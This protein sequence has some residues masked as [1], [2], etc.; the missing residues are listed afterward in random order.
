MLKHKE[1]KETFFDSYVW[2]NFIPKDHKY[3][4]IKGL[5]DVNFIP[6]LVKDSY[7]N[8]HPQ[9][10]DP[11]DPRIL[12]LMCIVE[13]L[14]NLSDVQVA[15][16]LAEVPVLKWFV[17]LA[18][19]D[20]VPDDTTLCKFRTQRMGE[21]NFKEAFYKIVNQIKEMGL[22]DGQVQSQDA[23]A[24]WAD[25]ALFNVFQLLNKCRQN[26]LQAI[27]KTAGQ[28]RYNE[29]TKRYDFKLIRNPADK[30]K[31]F[32]SLI[33]VCQGLFNEIKKSRGLLKN[34]KVKKEMQILGRALSERQDEYFDEDNKKQKK[35]EIDKIKG[36]MINPSDPDASW[37]AKSETKYFAG[38]KA[39]VNMDHLYDF[40]TAI[41]VMNAGHPEEQGAAP[42]LRE[43]QKY[44]GIIPKHFMADAKYSAG[45]TRL[46]LKALGID[47]LYLPEVRPKHRNNKLYT[48]YAF[49]WDWQL[50]NLV[51]P[52][53]YPAEY[54]H[55][56]DEKLGFEFQ[57]NERICSR[58]EL[59]GQCTGAEVCGRKVL[60]P[61]TWWDHK[62]GFR[63]MDTEEYKIMYKEQRYKIERKNADL[64]KWHG[65]G[66]V[67]YRGRARVRIQ[68][69]LTALAVN[70]K[71]WVKF[72]MGKLK[73]GINETLAK[74][75]A[76]APP[77]GEVRSDT[78]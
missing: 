28:T 13:Y 7:K 61:H 64:K 2:N 52:A 26:L 10:N 60:L 68:A 66:R 71:K 3:V 53:G 74:L 59:K 45:T 38:Y 34:K 27:L 29:L 67:R 41:N 57:F 69:F 62:E 21:E 76:L 51:C 9:G 65:F 31:H 24:I 43:Q 23:T 77:E 35:E 18:P 55:A 15:Q 70:I 12:F 46:E 44:L 11:I 6:E 49:A 78:G 5:I 63:I 16:K 42:L 32:E 72:A 75:A 39:E 4:K 48:S 22:I 14:E 20:K 30:Q 40:I 8:E 1:Y 36:K 50:M 56:D 73:N 54:M 25:I 33:Q 19:S 58:C 17:G 37:G 47:N